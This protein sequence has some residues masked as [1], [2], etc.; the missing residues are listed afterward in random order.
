MVRKYKLPREDF[1]I[2]EHIGMGNPK[3][4]NTY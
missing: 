2:I 1:N 4:R 3:F